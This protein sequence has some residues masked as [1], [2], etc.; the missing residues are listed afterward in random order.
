[1]KKLLQTVRAV[2]WSFVGLR[3]R[4]ES[5]RDGEHISLLSILL[6]GFLAAVLFVAA[7][8]AVVNLVV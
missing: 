3:D 6:V 2:L 5:L 1:M 8:I 7:L 4:K